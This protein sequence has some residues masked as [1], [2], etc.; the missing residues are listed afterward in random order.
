MGHSYSLSRKS[1]RVSTAVVF[2]L[3]VLNIPS[4]GPHE[5]DVYVVRRDDLVREGSRFDVSATFFVGSP[6]N[7]LYRSNIAMAASATENDSGG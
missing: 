3:F 1:D 5:G 6:N 2:D 4:T 7:L